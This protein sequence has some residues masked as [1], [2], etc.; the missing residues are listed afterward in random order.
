MSTRKGVNARLGFLSTT[1]TKRDV[2]VF[3]YRGT[4]K[5]VESRAVIEADGELKDNRA[6]IQSLRSGVFFGTRLR[7][8]QEDAARF[9]KLERIGRDYEVVDIM[10]IIDNR[11]E[12]L[13][14]LVT[15][16]IPLIHAD[17]GTGELIPI[18]MMGEGMVRMLSI[19]LGIM[20]YDGGI[21]LIDELENGLHYSVLQQ[22]WTAIAESARKNHVQI[23]AT[24]HSWECIRA[25]HRAFENTTPYDFRLHRLERNDGIINVVT[26]DQATIETS[27]DLN[28]EIR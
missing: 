10:K 13:S 6:P 5:S 18:P 8:S 21:I 11:L 1:Q 7:F 28:L 27:L 17:I 15:G 26:Y 4:G 25:A 3:E 16:G 20:S 14:V 23:F 2:L 9:S 12:R 24:T 22:V 19:I